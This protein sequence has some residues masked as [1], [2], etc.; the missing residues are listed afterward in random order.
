GGLTTDTGTIIVDGSNSSLLNSGLGLPFVSFGRGGLLTIRNNASGTLA[1]V[2]IAH[3]SHPVFNVESGADVTMDNLEL[4]SNPI[5]NSNAGTMNVTGTGTTV[6]QNSDATTTIG[7]ATDGSATLNVNNSGA[8]TSGTGNVL[9][10]NTGLLSIDGGVFTANGFFDLRGKLEFDGGLLQVTDGANIDA[11]S[12]V[13]HFSGVW[14]FAGGTSNFD[15]TIVSVGSLAGAVNRPVWTVRDNAVV[16]VAESLRI[17]NAGGHHGLIQVS[18]ATDALN[19]STLSNI[20]T[21]G[22]ADIIVGH[23]ANGELQVLAGGLVNFY[24]DVLVGNNANATGTL[25]VSGV[26]NNVRSTLRVNRNGN[27]SNLFVGNL[28]V[29]DMTIEDG[30]LVQVSNR[31]FL[32][33]NNGSDGMLTV[34]GS[35]GGFDATL[36]VDN[37]IYIGG[38]GVGPRGDGALTVESGGFVDVAGTT[39]IYAGTGTLT[40]NGGELSTTNLTIDA[41]STLNFNGGTITINGGTTNFGDDHSTIS[42]ATTPFNRP[43]LKVANGANVEAP[44]EWRIGD[45]SGEY[46]GIIVTGAS[47]GAPSRL[48][49][50]SETGGV[51]VGAAGD[52][53]LQVLNGGLVEMPAINNVVGAS[54]EGNG[55]V[56]VSGVNG[57][58]RST[59]RTVAGASLLRIGFN[60]SGTLNVTNGGLVDLNGSILIGTNPTVFG[61]VAVGGSQGG[62]DA[63]IRTTL[64][65]SVGSGDSLSVDAGGKLDVGGQISLGSGSTLTQSGGTIQAD[66]IN[67]VAGGLYDWQDGVLHVNTFHGDLNNQGGTFAPGTSPGLSH[68]LG[69]YTEN[70]FATIEI[71]I[72][73]L[74]LADYDRITVDDDAILAG[75][76]D[77]RLINLGGGLFEP[78]LGNSFNVLTVDGDL[79]GVFSTEILPALLPGLAWD[80]LYDYDADSV[81]L[82]VVAANLPGDFNGDF[83]VDAAD[84][85]TWRNN[86]GAADESALGG[87]GSNSGGVDIADYTLW[88]NNFGMISPATL[89]AD[90]VPEPATVGIVVLSLAAAGA[91]RRRILAI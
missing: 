17:A 70:A 11:A 86:L 77:V 8:Y 34:G 13:T 74:A 37:N 90:A 14:S 53:L 73:G 4:V 60:G 64:G 51:T 46:G 40:M 80:V 19:R 52:G 69:N 50:A 31:V 6:L 91:R 49:I 41:T 76:L 84:Y 75:T 16:E 58:L 3:T 36:N 65:I 71:E 54:Q 27:G 5:A 45:A 44:S 18:G 25:L 2:R 42:A 10:D 33:F 30:A 29:A 39:Q 67:R 21:N 85:T 26:E 89:Q 28:G 61:A 47:G 1:D 63:E 83:V 35:S 24:D 12:T 48:D 72:G 78:S 66:S 32:G 38:S 57:S 22:T 88:K 20:A 15:D 56:T 87:N 68:I 82:E 62:F 81:T 59:L 55:A 79:S 43:T 7:H 9:V 23:I